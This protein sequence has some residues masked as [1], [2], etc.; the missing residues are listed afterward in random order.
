VLTFAERTITV[1][2]DT[3]KC[4]GCE[5][6]ACIRA[7]QTFGR[8]ILKLKDGMPSVD[9]LPAEEV[10]RRGTECLACEYECWFRGKSAID[11]D[12]PIV[13]LEEYLRKRGLCA[14]VSASGRSA[15]S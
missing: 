2:I 1:T 15:V 12:V 9:H 4:A 7:C 14:T 11:I 10:K 5:S 8:G 3:S 13:G 6:K